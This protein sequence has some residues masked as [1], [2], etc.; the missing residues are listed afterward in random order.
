MAEETVESVD[1]V[2]GED[3]PGRHAE[4]DVPVDEPIDEEPPAPGE[5]GPSR[6][7]A[8]AGAVRARGIAFGQAWLRAATRQGAALIGGLVLC[9]SFP[10]WGFWWAAF[11]ALSILGWVFWSP[12]TRL[13]G[14]LGYG[15]LFGLAFFIPLLP[16]TG[17]LVGAVPWLALSLLCATWVALFGVLAV[18]VRNLPGWP[19]WFAA[20]WSAAEWG[21]ASVPFGGFPWGRIAFGQGD[22]PMLSLARYGGAPLVSFT[23]ALGAFAVTAL[24]IEMYRWW[25][26]P[27]LGPDGARPV[28]SVL[29]P[30]ACVC[31]VLI[32]MAVSWQQVRH[33]S[34]GATDGRTVTVAAVQGNVPRLGLD[35]NAQ[36]R[37]VLDYHVKETLLLAQDVKAGKAPAPQFVVWPENSSDID[38]IRNA[39]AAEAITEAAQ[40]IGVPI[41]VGGVLRHP[42]STPEQPKSI[43]SII[44]WDPDTGPG[45]R[46][47]KQIV[48]PFG[49]YLPWRSFFAHFSEY[50]DRAGYFVPGEGNGVVTA[51][52]VKIGVATCWEVLFDRALRQSTLN[53]AEILTVPSNNALFG[54]AMSEQQLAISKVRAVEHDREVIVV[55]TTGISAFISPDGVD[56]GR[57]KFFEPAYIDM[58]VRLH[59]DLTPATQWGPWIEWALALIAGLAVLASAGLAILHNGGLK[60]PEREVEPASPIKET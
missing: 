46:H 53:G 13:R 32:A 6:G 37:A 30:G 19:L 33:A 47:D 36:R 22:G 48:Q 38:P 14:G 42:D 54:T 26:S 49:E 52:G 4:V 7:A 17:Q 43:N 31:L 39:D 5:T 3:V 59:N 15:L 60:R 41:L 45:E 21:K 20:A 8:F 1:E 27:A 56:A 18:A 50:A 11:P 10:P 58:Q 2:V 51:G 16:W 34:H 24:G 29:L 35:F 9:A 40:A 12:K 44:V 55:G 28:P 25:R 23:V 57:T